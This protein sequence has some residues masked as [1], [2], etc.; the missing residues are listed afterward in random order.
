MNRRDF[1]RCMAALAALSALTG[2]P[3]ANP[4]Q[5]AA[6]VAEIAKAIGKLL[7]YFSGVDA[8]WAKDIQAALTALET[9]AGKWQKG[10][11][12]A[13]IESVVNALVQLMGAFPIAA[14][15]Q[16]L[17]TI[18]V[19]TLEGI[20]ALVIPPA[21]GNARSY[22]LG[23]SKVDCRRVGRH[24]YVD[25]TVDGHRQTVVDPPKTAAAFT[26]AWD[27]LA[28]AEMQI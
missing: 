15:Y 13:E 27:K 23:T 4:D 9:V 26:A 18:I 25:I 17:V 8:Q 21:K 2:C 28:P 22:V 6:L 20:L 12:L 16:P 14:P 24:V 10:D 19:A 11:P 5:I 3:T 7:P 1:V